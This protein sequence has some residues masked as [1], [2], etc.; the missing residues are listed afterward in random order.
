[1]V[2]DWGKQKKKILEN[3]MPHGTKAVSGK[4]EHTHTPLKCI[5]LYPVSSFT[6]IIEIKQHIM[7]RTLIRK[8]GD[9]G[10]SP[11]FA[12]FLIWASHL[13]SL[14]PNFLLSKMEETDQKISK[15]SSI[16]NIGE[17]NKTI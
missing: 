7:K 11:N 9:L 8:F 12:T 14:Q 16:L 3:L 17:I 2:F 13:I 1:M 5:Y 10:A 15:I 6:H 4:N